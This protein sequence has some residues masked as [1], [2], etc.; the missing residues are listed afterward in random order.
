MALETVLD[1]AKE[2]PERSDGEWVLRVMAIAEG[3]DRE[4]ADAERLAAVADRLIEV[5]EQLE[6]RCL[7]GASPAGD[8]LIGAMS[9]RSGGRVTR[10]V[11]GS[12]PTLVIE[13]VMA[14]GTQVVR[15]ARD[16]QSE[17]VERVAGVAVLADP[18]ALEF[19]R[20]ELNLDVRAL[21]LI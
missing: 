18:A 20:A 13:G 1:V 8:H 9:L 14:T 15:A 11:G 10:R 19:S 4:L 2:I 17:G 6:L 16:L 21:E 12:D 7:V 3:L 5:A